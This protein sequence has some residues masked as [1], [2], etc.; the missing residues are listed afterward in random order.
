MRTGHGDIDIR[1]TGKPAVVILAVLAV[2]FTWNLAVTRHTVDPGVERAIRNTLAA[3]YA[4]TV[5]PDIKEG[6]AHGDN[7]R[8]EAGTERL[9]TCMNKIT[10]PSLSSRGGRGHFCVRAEIRIDGGPPPDSRSVRY[11]RLSNTAL[12]GPVLEEETFAL[13]YYVPFLD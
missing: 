12:L 6:L 2:I 8:V 3:G 4:G 11:F 1:V 7:A 5:L 9:E 10:F 13:S